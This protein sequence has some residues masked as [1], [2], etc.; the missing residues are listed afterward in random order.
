[1]IYDFQSSIDRTAMGS[2]KWL[3]MHSRNPEVPK[4][5]AP[6]SVADLD[7]PNAPEIVEGLREYLLTAVLGYASPTPAFEASVVDW[8]CRRH[9]WV[10][11][12]EWR[13]DC[14]GVL[15]AFF[16][17]I[18]AYSEPGDGI[19]VNTPIYY[20]F[21]LAIERNART[22][23]RNP[24]VVQDGKYQIDFEGLEELARQPTNKVLLFC[25]P[26]NPTGRVWRREEL[27]RVAQ[28]CLDND[29]LLISDEIHFDLIMPGH[30][31][32]V[33]TT[34]GED[35]AQ[36]TIVCTAPSKT[37]NIAGMTTS[38]IIIP[39][40]D[41]RARFKREMEAQGL[42]RLNILGYKACELAY[43]R[44]EPWLDKLLALID[45]NRRELKNFMAK[46]LPEV[47]VFDL[48]GTYLQWMD[49]RPLG[50]EVEEL[51]RIMQ[52]E[53]FVFFDEGHI[54]G[55]EEGGGFERMNIACSTD[56]MLDALK[57]VVLAVR[58]YRPRA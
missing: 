33:M 30:R 55:R 35:I 38:N 25:S 19:I 11:E 58:A 49:F 17:A 52:H 21:Y 54:F 57:R 36:R 7:I 20:P 47:I 44:A 48:E 26:H 42:H 14:P 16:A 39:N 5:V 13:L 22:V 12:P 31:H 27:A 34:L 37:F 51:E 43:T 10:V 23:V 18:R 15:P 50:F 29:L 56:S 8:M 46:E 53:A 45:H 40:P 9:G 41:L 24:L 32:T 4:G 28:I 3:D 6:F 2:Y 1:M